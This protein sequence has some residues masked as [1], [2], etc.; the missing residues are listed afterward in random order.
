MYEW[1]P[2][3]LNENIPPYEGYKNLVQPS[4][5]ALFEAAAFRIGHSHVP[6]A[7]YTRYALTSPAT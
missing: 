2:A 4:I 7:I 6:P 3:F 5:S 1:L